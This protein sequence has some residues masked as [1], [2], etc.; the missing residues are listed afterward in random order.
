MGVPDFSLK[1][2][3]ALITG[4]SRG[5]GRSIAIALA[6]AGADV[7]VVSRKIDALEEVVTECKQYGNRAIAVA[8]HAGKLDQIDQMVDQVAA[9]FGKIDILVNNA[10]TNPM[11]AQI[12]NYEERLWDSVMNLNLK[13]VVFLTKKVGGLMKENGGGSII[14]IS[15][16][17]GFLVGD[18]SCAYDVS[19]AGL[20]HF[21]RVAAAEMAIHNIRVNSISPGSTKTALVKALWE[22][23]EFEKY[24]TDK[25]PQHRFADPD[26]MAGAAVYLASDAASYTTGTNIV[27]DGGMS[28]SIAYHDPLDSPS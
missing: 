2:K 9:E 10:G 28:L 15:S 4:A 17:E 14:N 23:A 24:I 1:G 22:N 6:H 12:I 13:G 7:A 5:I 8:T 18:L 3:T 19:K 11:N 16:V 25:I 26:E 27:I 20:T 21:T